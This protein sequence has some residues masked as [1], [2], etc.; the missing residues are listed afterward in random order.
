MRFRHR[1]TASL[2][3]L[4]LRSD[5]DD[6]RAVDVHERRG[7]YLAAL[8]IPDFGVGDREVLLGFDHVVRNARAGDDVDVALDPVRPGEDHDARLVVSLSHSH[9]SRIAWLESGSFLV[10]GYRF[11]G[12]PPG[13]ATTNEQRVTSCS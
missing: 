7:M 12:A 5:D 1:I 11:A 8:E 3:H 9:T 13:R 10:A 2:Y 4:S 6:V